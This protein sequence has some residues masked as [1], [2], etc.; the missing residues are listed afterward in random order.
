MLEEHY[1][2]RIPNRGPKQEWVIGED[3]VKVISE[4]PLIEGNQK[5]YRIEY[6]NGKTGTIWESQLRP[7]KPLQ[8]SS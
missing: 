6:E 1:L 3:C 7:M 5:L 8:P 4:I 2:I